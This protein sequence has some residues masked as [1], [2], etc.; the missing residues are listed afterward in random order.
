[1]TKKKLKDTPENP[2]EQQSL[3]VEP[4]I[5]PSVTETLVLDAEIEPEATP[6]EQSEQP[7]APPTE[8]VIEI[9]PQKRRPGRPSRTDPPVLR[10]A[11]IERVNNL[12]SWENTRVYAYRW[13]PFTDRK[14][15]GKQSVMVKRFD[16]PFDEMDVLE[17]PGMGSG[18]YEFVVNQTDPATRQRKIIDSGVVRLLNMKYPPRIPQKEWVDDERNK[19]WE[20]ARNLCDKNEA[21]G[22][23]PITPV[24]D[25]LI[26]VFRDQIQAQR[27]EARAQREENQRLQT[28]L[29][30]PKKNE[31][32]QTFMSMLAP[33]VPAIVAKL[34]AAPAPAPP[35]PDPFAM[36]T[37]ALEFMDKVRPPQANTTATDPL[38]ELDRHLELQKK[39]EEAGGGRQSGRSRKTGTQEMI[40][41]IASSIAPA[42]AP[43]FQVIAHGMM[44]AQKSGTAQ[45]QPAPAPAPQPTVAAIAP[46]TETASINRPAAGPQIVKPRPTYEAVAEAA[47][48]FLA[49]RK[50]GFELGDWFNETYGIE[51]FVEFRVQG[52]ENLLTGLKATPSWGMI[53]E[54][55]ETGELNKVLNEFLTWEP[56]D[57]DDDDEEEQEIGDDIKSGWDAAEKQEA[58]S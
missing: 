57:D 27:E 43:I 38:S 35:P 55:N 52:K 40:T 39:I 37:A 33:F 1:M 48:E 29:L 51:Q 3:D 46:V 26:G 34:T 18:V 12:K 44:Q 32:E 9:E 53:S 8:Q 49:K 4:E 28:L 15:G 21:P 41:E 2:P 20:W 30:T 56:G 22:S 14:A 42:V 6:N 23:V 45:Q 58:K 54:F 7:E 24:V 10:S 19:D 5:S 11:V 17:D 47:H 13:E 31:G 36:M 50:D 25:P 16:G